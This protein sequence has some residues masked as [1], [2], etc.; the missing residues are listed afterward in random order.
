MKKLFQIENQIVVSKLIKRPLSEQKTSVSLLPANI[1]IENASINALI[2][3][4]NDMVLQRQKLISSAGINNPTVK[5][6]EANLSN[7]K[8][9]INSSIT[10]Y[11]TQLSL[12][13]DQLSSRNKTFQS[14]VSEIPEKEQQ[15]R[16]IERQQNIKE[17]LFIFLLQKKE[18]ASVN[19]AVTEPT[20]KLWSIVFPVMLQ[21]PLSQIWFI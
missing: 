4:F 17:T 18:E 6:L 2:K 21:F 14:K 19:L 20:L 5:L 13:R 7:L 9:N 16:A 1:G 10:A 11:I 8:S 3:N 12:T 15:L